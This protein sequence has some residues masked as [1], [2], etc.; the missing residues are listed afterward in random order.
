MK[1]SY[2]R[3]TMEKVSRSRNQC[4][5]WKVDTGR[6][7]R[8]L[9]GRAR[10]QRMPRIR[11]SVA[12]LCLFLCVGCASEKKY[13][14]HEGK[15]LAAFEQDVR[16]CEYDA[17]RFGYIQSANGGDAALLGLMFTGST[18][19]QNLFKACMRAKGYRRLTQKQIDQIR[20]V[21]SPND[22]ITPPRGT[23]DSTDLKKILP[24]LPDTLGQTDSSRTDQDF[25]RFLKELCPNSYEPPK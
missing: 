10:R 2:I 18:P 19:Q 6:T 3:R 17:L 21:A 22:P 12:G 8:S 5:V 13:W 23:E 25:E 16:E 14:Y 7:G 11:M 4:T 24:P 9:C 20:G 15:S 1:T